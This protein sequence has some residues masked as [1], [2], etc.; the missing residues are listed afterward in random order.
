MIDFSLTEEERLLQETAARFA[1]DLLRDQERDH[2]KNRSFPESLHKAYAELGFSELNHA[3]T[4][5]ESAHRIAVWH[6]LAQGDPAAPF[7]LDPVGPGAVV[8]EELP[9]GMGAFSTAEGLQI[10]GNR[11]HGSIAWLPRQRLDYLVLI[12]A[13][14]L[15]LVDS[16][17]TKPLDGRPVGLQACGGIE[18]ILDN[19]ELQEVGDAESAT[20]ALAE[21]RRMA[22]A[23]MLG[24]A[25]DAHHAAAVYTQERIVFGR[26]IAHHQGMAFQLADAATNIVAAQL[27]LE[28]STSCATLTANAHAMAVEVADHICERSV[29]A[30]GGHG[31]LYDHRIEKRMRDVRALASLYGG[32]IQ[33]ELDAAVTILD[34][35]D[36]LEIAL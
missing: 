2:E 34:L 13:E 9:E 4:G 11:V 25:L 22:A 17:V 26:P 24:A 14:G 33:S 15:F 10:S 27:L 6:T 5:L 23:T 32:P 28:A 16:P 30:L 29:Q 36:P 20:A 19:T 21:C 3:N 7:G 1:D 35:S 12:T 31:Y 8:L 18:V